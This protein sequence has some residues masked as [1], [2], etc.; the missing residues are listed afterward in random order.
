MLNLGADLLN[1]LEEN[2]KAKQGMQEL[3]SMCRIMLFKKRYFHKKSEM[4]I[5]MIFKNLSPYKDLLE[6]RMSDIFKVLKE[7]EK[8]DKV[9]CAPTL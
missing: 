3:K 7:M 5:W 8:Q 9:F 2:L 4:D 6:K 1:L